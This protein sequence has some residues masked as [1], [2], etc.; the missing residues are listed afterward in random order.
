MSEF[1]TRARVWALLSL[2]VYAPLAA[3]QHVELVT[4]QG[5]YVD[6]PGTTV[7]FQP[8]AM[9]IAADGY[10][11][12]NDINGRLMRLNTATGTVTALPATPGGLNHDLGWS[13]GIA[14]DSGIPHVTSQGGLHRINHDG[15]LTRLRDLDNT[16]P[17]AFGIGGTI[18]MVPGDNRVHAHRRDGTVRI[19]AGGEEAGFAGDGGPAADALLAHPQGVAIGPDG[20]VYVAD[21]DNHRIRKID[22]ATGIITTFA[23][24]G[25]AGYGGDGGP[26]DQAA[27]GTPLGIAADEA[28][29]FYVGVAGARRVVRIDA[30]S[31]L[32]S[33]VA[34]NG[35][36]A[37]SGDGGPA[38]DAGVS[39]P[40]FVAVDQG[41][42][43]YFSD[44]DSHTYIRKV[45]ATTGV[46][47]RAL[48]FPSAH[49]CGEGVP[50]NQGC[51]AQPV[52]VD[53]QRS[54]GDV[55]V[56][57]AALMRL[58][59]IAGG[60]V[61]T[62]ATVA[63]A[64]SGA[65]HDAAG[66]L[67]VMG[68]GKVTR[69]DR[70]TGAPTVVAGGNGSGFGGDGGPATAARLGSVGDVAVD[71][72]GNLLISDTL[73][74]RIRKVTAATGI[75]TTVQTFASPSTIEISHL[76]E[77]YVSDGCRVHRMNSANFGVITTFGTSSCATQDPPGGTPA[78]TTALGSTRAF[79]LDAQG[80]F[81]VAWSNQIYRVSHQTSTLQLV[82]RPPQGWV[83][84]EG[85]KFER[86]TAM[87]FDASGRLY[88]AQ[89]NK[90]FLFRMTGLNDNTPP[91]ITAHVVGSKGV[92]NWYRSDVHVTFTVSDP[93]SY[94]VITSGCQGGAVTTDTNDGFS[95]EFACHATSLGGTAARFEAIRRDTRLPT[96]TW[97]TPT[98]APDANGW[99]YT[100]VSIPF[101]RGDGPSGLQSSSAT[102]PL[103]ISGEGTGLT[104]TVTLTDFA[105][106]TA[107]FTSP[108]VNITR[109]AVIQEQ[110]TGTPGNNG[111]YRSDVEVRWNIANASNVTA[112]S[113]CETTVLATDTA[114]TTLTCTVT[115]TGGSTSKSVTVKRDV[116]PPALSFGAL[117][118]LPN[119]DGWNQGV[120]DVP[121]AATDAL[122]GVASAAPV[123]PLVFAEPGAA[124][125]RQVE[126][127]D[128]AGNVA[129][130]QSPPVSI[131]QSPPTVEV[132]VS[133]PPGNDGWYRGEVRIDF[134]VSSPLSPVRT[135]GGCL[136]ATVNADT[137][138]L[139]FS[140]L[141]VNAAGSTTKAV[142][143]KVDQTAPTVT[144]GAAS[145]AADEA[146][147]RAPPLSVPF[148]VSDALSGIAST[149]S[150]S[151]L[152][153]TR[154]GRGVRGEVVVTD[155]AGNSA[156][157]S[158]AAF[159][160][161][162]TP[163]DLTHFIHGMQGQN[164]WY[165]TDARVVF[166]AVDAENSPL[167]YAGECDATLTTDSPGTT[168]TCTATSAGG[169]V[170]QSVT[171][172]RDTTPPV[173]TWGAPSPAAND[174]GW[175]TT[176]VAFPFTLEDAT[177]GLA[178]TSQGNFDAVIV[179]FTGPGVSS[180]ISAWD[181]AG[182]QATF[183][184]P[185]VNIDRF[186]PLVNFFVEGTPGSNGWYTSDV[187]VTWQVVKAPESILAQAGCENGAVTED[188]VGTTF[189]C[190]VTSGAGTTSRSV[191]IKR[192][193]SAPVLSFGTPSPVPNAA[194]WN[195]TNV[196]IPFTAVDAVSGIAAT[197]TA[198][199]LVLST[200]GANVTGEVS[201]TDQAGNVATFAS[202]A[203]NIDKTP[204]QVAI[205]APQNGATYGFY[206]DVPAN[207][208]CGD[209]SPATCTGTVANGAL[210][211][212]RT[213]GARTFTVTGRDA[214]AFATTRTS[215]FTVASTFN[216]EGF[217]PEVV[218][219]PAA[220]LVPRQQLVPIR[221]RLPDG[222][223][224][225]VSSTASFTGTSVTTVSCTGLTPVPLDDPAAGPSGITF[226]PATH[227]FT[228]NWQSGNWSGCRRL[229]L[230]FRDGSSR[231]L[232]F[233]FQ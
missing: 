220:N 205:V 55:V 93:E 187:Q 26:A 74:G 179:P 40:R 107:T 34:G 109:A 210:V 61:A 146:G 82:R 221:W 13:W 106:N 53:V 224:G 135:S 184:T 114:G 231:E 163:P 8:G 102:S 122:S 86:P 47:S 149:S 28:G 95:I 191:T 215:A 160:V 92:G 217:L 134:T 27:L 142:T 69:Y 130:F 180:Q 156:T 37:M 4:G 121:Y 98:P 76:G 214:V 80:N 223:G 197:G 52:A 99:N 49:F 177:S 59:R 123:S 155:V 230:R 79:T 32:V 207:Y 140:C 150:V 56:A 65:D 58:R 225:F 176:D 201:A 44:A 198:S 174:L 147:W 41:A 158:T 132:S 120:V 169:S 222:N 10:L 208:S 175:H 83:T 42:N 219:P 171:V 100:N 151:P 39:W 104:R 11:Y 18:Y 35:T 21:T 108:P 145:P 183:H 181:Q 124:Q 57:D 157:V 226:D 70:L 43:V 115:T 20:N 211:N 212:T 17:M 159:D 38:L 103:V 5:R 119:A 66:N 73:N 24:T 126:V 128:L 97:G 48:G 118:P 188:T 96:L 29:N 189:S 75:I 141:A 62:L 232:L 2:V 127:I 3:S 139:T 154:S 168:Y 182:N 50:A 167:S 172:R 209:V 185:P 33:T 60:N 113:G 84:A 202:V 77:I 153:I 16:G 136:D 72:A 129:T 46:V 116:T 206:Q 162:G 78:Q 90:P 94:A 54:S 173:L 165:R 227:V 148:E 1:F 218:L 111:W 64:P 14:V 199:P 112:T 81:Y 192:D 200:E 144:F 63:E 152:A 51:L 87:S 101:T 186:P 91:V 203:R 88:I 105:G 164:G 216:W 15:T 31:T 7:G 12:T 85:V 25:A 36:T 233:R 195:K 71:A 196:S 133:G 45:D 110:V 190:S 193:A 229:Q 178:G 161:D 6:I 125:S 170:T 166:Q 228:Y 30:V 138:G 137:A 23:G 117:S 22:L 213:A 19:I 89:G 67:Y 143:I 194:G 131:D 204:P 9:A 68:G